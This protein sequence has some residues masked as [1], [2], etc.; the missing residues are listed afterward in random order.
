MLPCIIV[1]MDQP[2][3]PPSKHCK[4][5][6]FK[7][8]PRRNV[9][10]TAVPELRPDSVP[11]PRRGW[12]K[13]YAFCYALQIFLEPRWN[14]RRKFRKLLKP[15]AFLNNV[16]Y[17]RVAS[18]SYPGY[19]R[20]TR[21]PRNLFPGRNSWSLLGRL[22]TPTSLTLRVSRNL[23]GTCA[24]EQ[25]KALASRPCDEIH[26]IQTWGATYTL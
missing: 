2:S 23:A 6:A 20:G 14:P 3:L 10:N 18:N 24:Q 19:L 15:F 17:P 8:I 9:G 1:R 5:L 21:V 26:D 16:L 22:G 7:F 11:A 25:R 13:A 12:Y 4:L